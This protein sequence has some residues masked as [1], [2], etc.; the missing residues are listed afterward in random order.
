MSGAEFL[1]ISGISATCEY[2]L[3]FSDLL[4]V[5]WIFWTFQDHGSLYWIF[6]T[7]K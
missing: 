4:E 5:G 2:N 6:H 1:D 3:E 7:N